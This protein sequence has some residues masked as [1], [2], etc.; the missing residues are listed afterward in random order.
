M[1]AEDAFYSYISG[2]SEKEQKVM[3]MRHAQDLPFKTVAKEIGKTISSLSTVY[4]RALKKVKK[5]LE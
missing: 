3:I 2:L 4:Y 1:L 5:T